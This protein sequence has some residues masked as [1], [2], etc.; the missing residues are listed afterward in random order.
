MRHLI[1]QYLDEAAK[2]PS[3][4]E[5]L[6]VGVQISPYRETIRI[7]LFDLDTGKRLKRGDRIYGDI[8]IEKAPFQRLSGDTGPCLG[9]YIVKSIEATRGYGPLLYDVA[10]EVASSK[11]SGLVPDRF[12]VSPEA[13]KVWDYYLKRRSDVQAVQLDDMENTLT[14]DP[15]DNCNQH[16]AVDHGQDFPGGSLTML[17][18]KRGTPTINSLRKL[19][20]LAE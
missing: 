15:S 16:S 11:A 5:I 8:S 6:S 17:Y 3:D 20:L 10:I 7:W 1:E 14:S 2:T 12:S 19:G 4:L 13:S 18:M 9:G